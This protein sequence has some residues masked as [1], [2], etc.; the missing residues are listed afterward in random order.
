MEKITK[1]T[2]INYHVHD[3]MFELGLSPNEVLVY[4]LIYSFTKGKTGVY[5]GSQKYVASVIGI[6]TRTVI[7]IYKKLF[8][9]K[10]I[11]KCESSTVFKK[12]I[13]AVL[14]KT[15]F[16]NSNPSPNSKTTESLEERPLPKISRPPKTA[17][18]I[19]CAIPSGNDKFALIDIP[20]CDAVALTEHQYRKLRELVGNDVLYAYTRRFQRYLEDRLKTMQPSPRSHYKLIKSWIE[21]DFST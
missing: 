13:R 21:E 5:Y 7:R 18:Q 15:V 19:E 11:E 14:P 20:N 1:N 2:L 12:G 4:A 17:A 9:L 6:S 10:L 8:L 16:A 3:F